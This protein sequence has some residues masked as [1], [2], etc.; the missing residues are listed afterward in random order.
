MSCCICI[1]INQAMETIWWTVQGALRDDVICCLLVCSANCR[2]RRLDSWI[3]P[4]STYQHWSALLQCVA[5]WVWPRLAVED[6]LVDGCLSID[7]ILAIQWAFVSLDRVVDRTSFPLV[8]KGRRDFSVGCFSSL[9]MVWWRRWS[10]SMARRASVRLAARLLSSAGGMPAS[11]G[12]KHPV[13]VRRMQFRLTSNRP[14]CL[15]LLHV[16]AQYSAGGYTSARAE[17]RSV[18]GLAPHPVPTSLRMSALR[19]MTLSLSPARCCW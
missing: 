19:A 10:G 16:G 8:A 7:H 2:S 15:L 3:G 9:V 5:Y 17:V 4:V 14:V 1:N 13:I 18:D 11:T 12:C 6:L